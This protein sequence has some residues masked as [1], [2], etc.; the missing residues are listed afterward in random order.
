[1]RR[2]RPIVRK[3]Y[4]SVVRGEAMT[5]SIGAGSDEASTTASGGE[6]ETST[7]V[8][9]STCSGSALGTVASGFGASAV[10]IIVGVVGTVWATTVCGTPCGVG[11]PACA[12]RPNSWTTNIVSCPSYTPTALAMPIS[13][14]LA[15]R[16]FS[17][18]DG[19]FIQAFSTSEE[20]EKSTAKFSPAWENVYPASLN[21]CQGSMASGE[22]CAK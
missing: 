10:A 9:P 17:R 2:N 20:S 15:S 7:F 12:G 3:L 13:V 1:M 5:Y 4:R 8:V 22:T 18:C 6:V 21:Q 16:I 11:V 19:E 14:Y